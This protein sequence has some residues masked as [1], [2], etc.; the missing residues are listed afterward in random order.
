MFNDGALTPEAN[1]ERWHWRAQQIQEG[2]IGESARWGDAREGEVVKVPT[3][4]TI[5]LMTVDLWKGSMD[6]VGGVLTNPSDFG[7][8]S[9]SHTDTLSRLATDGLWVSAIGAPVFSQF[10]GEVASGYTL[11]LSTSTGGSTI[12][13]TT[14]G[15]D[16]RLLGG[17]IN[18]GSATAG[19][20]LQINNSLTVRARTRT[21]GGSWSALT[22]AT[23]VV[24]L[25]SDGIVISEINYHPS[26]VTAA[27]IAVMPSVVEDD[28]EFIEIVNTHP[29]DSLN[30]LGMSL[31]NGVSYTFGNVS[32][33]PGEYGLV[34]ED[35]AA[36]ELRY[37][38]GQNVLGEWSGGVS[39][40]GETI[41]LRDGLGGVIM[42]VS[43]A[44]ANPWSEAPDGDG[45]TLELTDPENTPLAELGKWYR[46]RASTE[47]GGSP[48]A[49]GAG[50]IGVVISEVMTHSNQ[51]LTDAIELHN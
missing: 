5:P 47:F 29:T 32:L 50:P 45:P 23:F 48:G 3:T 30:L 19:T 27:E 8:F 36:F 24:S 7:F 25:G 21:A 10:G 41:E 13:Y 49:A 22:E 51:P 18:T 6:D 15:E 2:I 39:N 35:Q 20:S 14:N 37:G 43:Y 4:T 38:T 44:D 11:N 33:A 42:A 1:K 40:S 28:F 31:A 46:W 17:A 26:N 12:Y 9:Q 34:V 16:P